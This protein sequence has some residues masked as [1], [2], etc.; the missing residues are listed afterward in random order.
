MSSALTVVGTPAPRVDGLAK[1]TGQATYGAD[2]AFPGMLW[3]KYTRSTVPHAKLVRVDTAK[4]KAMPGVHAVITA[5]D[6]P[7]ILWGRLMMDMPV[8]ARGKVRFLGE[9]IAAVAA[10]DADVAEAAALAVEVEYEE[11]PAI[12]D[13]RE[14]MNPDAVRIHEDVSKYEGVPEPVATEPNTMSHIVW[15]KGNIDDGF[16]KAELVIEH[17]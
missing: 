8:L 7:N 12:F 6:I 9:P 10:D 11:L 1:V 3:C 17:E 2:V 5:E 14:A 4:A 16:K 15:Q 13:P